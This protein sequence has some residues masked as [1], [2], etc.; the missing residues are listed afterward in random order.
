MRY[1]LGRLA[2]G[3]RI[4]DTSMEHSLGGG[5][6]HLPTTIPATLAAPLMNAPDVV[7]LYIRGKLILRM[8]G[9][10]LRARSGQEDSKLR[11]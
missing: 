8:S 5:I 4:E 1:S 3:V 7:P 10:S 6:G 9:S 2:Q 11:S